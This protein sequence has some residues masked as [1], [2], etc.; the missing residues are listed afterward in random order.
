MNRKLD[1][2]SKLVGLVK[3]EIVNVHN[4]VLG[5]YTIEYK[6]E[7]GATDTRDTTIQRIQPCHVTP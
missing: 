6:E 3:A 7:D 4:T 2:D 5:S 1:G